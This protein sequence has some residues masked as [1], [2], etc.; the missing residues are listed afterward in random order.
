VEWGTVSAILCGA[1][2]VGW[3]LVRVLI[4]EFTRRWERL[5]A[6]SGQEVEKKKK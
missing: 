4:R 3:P 6:Q 5:N 1:L 2:L